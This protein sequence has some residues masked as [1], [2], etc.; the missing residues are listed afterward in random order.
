MATTVITAFNEFQS[1][2]VNLDPDDTPLARTSRD[3]L[4]DRIREFPER[5]ADFPLLYEEK[6]IAYGSFS[7]RTKIRPLDDIDMISC[8]HAS[9]ATYI[10]YQHD[11]VRITVTDTSRLKSYCHESTNTLNS[12]KVINR[13]VKALSEI[14]Q[15]RKA[16]INRRGETATLELASYDWN[17]DI[18]PAF[19]TST[20]DYG[21]TYYL[22]PNGDGHW[23]KADPRIDRDRVARV[24]KKHNGNMLNIIRCVKYWQR[25][26]TMP[27]MPSY[28]LECIVVAHFE[29][30]TRE[31]S[32]FV[33]IEL[34]EVFRGVG[35]AILGAVADP[36]GIQQDINSLSWEDRYSI[37]NRALSDAGKV[38]EARSLEQLKDMKGSI[39]RWREIFGSDFPEY[40]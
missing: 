33:D 20:D 38:D 37:Y 25:R 40:D 22:I 14:P 36:K 23:K 24:N 9:G 28:L 35:S 17:F 18:A 32:Q 5:H 31:A 16:E 3:W 26:K 34:A 19:M 7:R 13:Y 30:L 39:S 10:A 29:A 1:D 21:K 4:F 12:R 6:D 15:Y 11:D 8:L 2:I 27:T